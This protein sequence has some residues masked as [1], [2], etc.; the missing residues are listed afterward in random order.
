MQEKID[1][2]EDWLKDIAW[3]A[4]EILLQEIQPQKA[5]EIAG[6]QA[7]WP[8]LNKQQLYDSVFM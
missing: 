2:T 1:I 8:M 4:S 3:F 5:M 6:P 7:F